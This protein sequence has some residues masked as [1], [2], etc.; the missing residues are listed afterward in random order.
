MSS[1]SGGP[2]K[3]RVSA[4]EGLATNST[5]RSDRNDGVSDILRREGVRVFSASRTNRAV[6]DDD[7]SRRGALVVS[8]M[9]RPVRQ[10][11]S[12]PPQSPSP[13]PTSNSQ[14]K[15]QTQTHFHT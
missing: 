1:S 11:R 5:G 9:R 10:R 14:P 13:H 8:G 4:Q 2:R 3:P 12:T 6:R 15:T 7:A